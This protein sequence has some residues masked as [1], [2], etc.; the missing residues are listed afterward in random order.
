MDVPSE[1]PFCRNGTVEIAPGKV[2]PEWHTYIGIGYLTLFSI[3]I[4]PQIFVFLTA[5]QKKIIVHSCY[6]LMLI[7]CIL[8]S[9]H[10]ANALLI[11]GVLSLLNINHCKDGFGVILYGHVIMYFWFFYCMTNLVLAVNRLLELSNKPLAKTLFHGRRTWFW[12]ILPFTYATVLT[13]FDKKPIYIYDPNAGMWYFF[14]NTED[15][16]NYHHVYNNLAKFVLITSLYMVMIIILRRAIK[17]A[18]VA[19]SELEIKFSIQVFII[20]LFCAAATISY[21]AIDYSSLN[22]T[23]YSGIIAD[24]LC[25]ALNASS[26]FVYL[27]LN[28]SVQ[29]TAKTTIRRVAQLKPSNKIF[30]VSLLTSVNAS[31][32]R[33]S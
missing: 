14:W 2:Q 22:E 9:H 31:S 23:A 25:A 20:S 26:G 19:L 17:N 27:T 16:T 1:Q 21:I 10:L 29:S 30:I 7:T 12:L 24:L 5:I 33:D 15:H 4:V 11:P 32:N 18:S 28:R 6:K 13:V 8:D 3:V